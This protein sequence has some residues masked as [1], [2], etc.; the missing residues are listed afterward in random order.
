M[1]DVIAD[2]LTR[3][4]NGQMR[5]IV[6]VHVPYSSFRERVL[7][8]LLDEGYISYSKKVE[9]RKSIYSLEVGLK[10]LNDGSPVISEIKKVS[11]PGCR[12]YSGVSDLSGFYN[13]LGITILSTS[14]GVMSDRQA[15]KNGVGGEIICQVF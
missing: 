9:L 4:R 15:R 3:L 14:K 7:N 5:K 1:T 11:K 2:M 8:I 6:S 10:Y 12:L 13:N